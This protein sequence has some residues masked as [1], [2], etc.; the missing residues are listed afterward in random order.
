MTI[1]FLD[2]HYQASGARAV[3]V[4][5]DAWESESPS[6]MYVKN[7]KT[8]QAYE[9]GY[10]FRRELPCLLSVLRLLPSLPEAAVVDGYVWLPSV[11]RPGLGAHLY[12]ALG[13]R[14]PVVGIAKS[15]FVG[16]ESSSAVA[17]VFRGASRNP[18][19]VTAMGMEL[20]VA[21]QCVRQMAGKYRIP[22]MMRIADRL[23]KGAVLTRQHAV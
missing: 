3:C 13:R 7:I 2:V 12:D 4:L 10:F 5:A 23:S 1:A 9:P 14:T 19:F 16:A 17:R 8:V 18:L 21:A 22:E 20:E 6:R 15:A 11:H